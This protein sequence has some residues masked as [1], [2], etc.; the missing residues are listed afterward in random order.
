MKISLAEIRR[1]GQRP[2]NE[3]AYATKRVFRAVSPLATWVLLRLGASPN[4]VSAAS[5]L[6][7]LA[8]A[9][10]VAFGR[11]PAWDLGGVALIQLA[12]VLS[13]AD[14]EVA[15]LRRMQSWYGVYLDYLG[16]KILKPMALLAV[17]VIASYRAH[18]AGW[19][20]YAGIWALVMAPSF[21]H[22]GRGWVF[23]ERL[24]A[25]PEAADGKLRHDG[26]LD[27]P[28]EPGA[29]LPQLGWLAGLLFLSNLSLF[30]IAHVVCMVTVADMLLGWLWPAAP[31]GFTELTLA[32]YVLAAP[33]VKLWEVARARK[34]LELEADFERVLGAVRDP[35]FVNIQRV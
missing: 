6:A 2:P 3:E 33:L 4:Q 35:D 31:L 26:T 13:L 14:G 7:C 34:N 18:D 29:I 1:G 12:L 10:L 23:L 19:I 15:R 27:A 9:A 11:H 32:F 17:L 8:G 20:L 21:D 28:P 22:H 24:K 30:A 25:T 5:D 16:Y